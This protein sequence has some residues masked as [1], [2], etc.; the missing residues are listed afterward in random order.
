MGRKKPKGDI[1]RI[2]FIFDTKEGIRP[3][4]Q[5]VKLL[6]LPR[7]KVRCF[8]LL[9]FNSNEMISE[10][11][12]RMIEV[13]NAGAMPFAQLY[14]PADRWINYPVEWRGFARTWSRP[15]AMK[16]VMQAVMV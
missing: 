5:A 4:R 2:F 12:E 14:Q 16:A 3:L 15:A 1:E 11:T 6:A 10:A 8:V 9:K 13:W 7:A